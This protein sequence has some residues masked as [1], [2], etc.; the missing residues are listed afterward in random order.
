MQRGLFPAAA[1]GHA[2]PGSHLRLGPHAEHIAEDASPQLF[3][4]SRPPLSPQVGAGRSNTPKVQTRAPAVFFCHVHHPDF[5]QVNIRFPECLPQGMT[6]KRGPF[7]STT[8]RNCKATAACM[9]AVISPTWCRH[10]RLHCTVQR[11]FRAR[12]RPIPSS[13]G[14]HSLAQHPQQRPTLGFH[15]SSSMTIQV[16]TRSSMLVHM[17]EATTPW[18]LLYM[19]DCHGGSEDGWK[20]HN[21]ILAVAHLLGRAHNCCWLAFKEPSLTE[22]K[23]W[24]RGCSKWL[25]ARL[26]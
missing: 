4:S 11:E 5:S 23:A 13:S 7:L 17:N 16:L 9:Q 2:Q 26:A 3:G 18:A 15:N 10:M 25:R 21:P 6:T 20:F 14:S 1:L 19:I 24:R 12:S 8:P 22:P